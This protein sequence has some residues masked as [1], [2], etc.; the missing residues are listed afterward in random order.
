MSDSF[1]MTP[2]RV[3]RVARSA[4]MA[5]SQ[6]DGPSGGVALA[7]IGGV[8]MGVGANQQAGSH[9]AVWMNAWFDGGCALILIGVLL[10]AGNLIPRFRGYRDRRRLS[11]GPNAR[12]L[13]GAEG[14]DESL[15][16]SP[17]VLEV[18][19]D[20]L[21]LHFGTVWVLGLAVRITNISD[22]PIILAGYSLQSRSGIDTRPPLAV[23][24]W[25]SV[26]NCK[27]RLRQ[28]HADEMFADVMAIAP[29]D[30]RVAGGNFAPRLSQIRT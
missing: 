25:D 6:T 30:R 4:D 18:A 13:P 10:V 28:V 22:K 19:D 27:V 29:H 17:L 15:T 21:L 3:V 8:V 12:E 26:N 14:A 7:T 16:P 2:R 11:C 1:P 20:T 23:Q 9:Q 5:T 24:V